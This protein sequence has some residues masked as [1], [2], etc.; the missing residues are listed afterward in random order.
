M[1]SRE[2]PS[3]QRSVLVDLQKID[4]QSRQ[5]T[6]DELAIEE[7]LEIRIG[8]VQEGQPVQRSISVTMR[9]PG[10]DFELAAG[11]LFTEMLIHS[12]DEI[13]SIAHCGRAGSDEPRNT[14]RVDLAPSVHVD[15]DKLQRNFYTTSSCGVCGKSSIEAL[16]MGRRP[17]L[18]LSS[19]RLA[20]E[21]IRALPARL[22]ASQ[23][24]FE[25]TGGLHAAGLFSM[26]G[27]LLNAREDVGRHNAV[28]KIIGAALM[29]DRVPLNDRV[30]MLSGRISFEL[31]QKALVAG[32]PVI[33]AIGAPSS[34][35]I[36]TAKTFG[37]TVIGFVRDDRFNVYS[38]E[39]RLSP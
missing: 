5:Q 39:E 36:E 4:K 38:G 11:F 33:V 2:E 19:R 28:D 30:L 18:P 25:A 3:S 29:E 32:I 8:F 1:T 23:A 9:T 20:P 26:E 14:V 17:P 35:A 12:R 15:L 31:A 16:Q 24:T 10:N 7:P 21:V 6:S 27:E 34:L 37:M 13:T 22:R